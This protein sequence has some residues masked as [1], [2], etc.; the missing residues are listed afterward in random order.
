M[1]FDTQ[2]MTFQSE[3]TEGTFVVLSDSDYCKLLDGRSNGKEIVLDK[4]NKPKL[5]AL[6]MPSKALLAGLEESAWRE[7]EL[8]V[9]RRQL[10]ALEEDEAGVPPLDL[11]PGTRLQWL[12]YRGHTNNWVTGAKG[13]PALE[14][15]PQRPTEEVKNA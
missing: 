2:T 1:Y 14:S 6:P 15:R 10:E 4:Y 9:I 8:V 7:T 3:D 12:A 13:Y 5:K 11:L